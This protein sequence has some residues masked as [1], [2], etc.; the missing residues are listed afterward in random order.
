MTSLLVKD[1]YKT[2]IFELENGMGT[3]MKHSKTQSLEV[4]GTYLKRKLDG[5]L[6][7]YKLIGIWQELMGPAIASRTDRMFIKKDFYVNMNSAP[8]KH[9]LNMSKA[10]VLKLI[11][12]DGYDVIEDAKF[13]RK[14]SF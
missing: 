1:K 5:K 12:E 7:E 9:E 14:F 8:L 2:K 6:N 10:K 3:A 13:S 4:I 11:N